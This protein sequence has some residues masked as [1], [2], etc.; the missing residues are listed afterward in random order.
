MKYGAWVAFALRHWDPEGGNNPTV[1]EESPAKE[2]VKGRE[3]GNEVRR[4]RGEKE[5]L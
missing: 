2:V 1:E 5:E 4:G 3:W